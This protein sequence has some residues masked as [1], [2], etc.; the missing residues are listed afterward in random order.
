MSCLSSHKKS[1]SFN[2]V[3]LFFNKVSKLSK[4]VFHFET[5][6]SLEL[7][8]VCKIKPGVAIITI[9]STKNHE[10]NKS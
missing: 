8:S 10:L 7:W 9:S 5:E 1:F 4:F 3:V 6:T 2:D